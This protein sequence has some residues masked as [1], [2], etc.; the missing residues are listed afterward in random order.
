[1]SWEGDF[2]TTAPIGR[3]ASTNVIACFEIDSKPR[4]L[5]FECY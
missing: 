4:D 5:S 2:Q 1:M 3:K